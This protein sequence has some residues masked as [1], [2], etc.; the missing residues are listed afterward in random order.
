MV[1]VHVNEFH[2]LEPKSDLVQ[3][4]VM[5]NLQLRKLT[6]LFKRKQEKINR[7]NTEKYRNNEKKKEKTS[8]T[9]HPD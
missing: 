4:G 6:I 2:S 9:I 8:G 1:V 3:S 5:E 7:K